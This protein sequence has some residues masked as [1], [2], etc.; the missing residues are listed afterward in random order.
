MW[1]N[2]LYVYWQRV[3]WENTRMHQIVLT[4]GL[5]VATALL[6]LKRNNDLL[7]HSQLYISQGCV[8]M[9]C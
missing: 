6:T 2:F 1:S 3:R 4:G 5:F 9:S 8:V 7:C